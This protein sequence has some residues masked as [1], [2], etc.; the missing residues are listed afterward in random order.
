VTDPGR[1]DRPDL[2]ERH[3][4][5]RWTVE[6]WR[7]GA[8]ALHALDWPE[9]LRPTIWVLEVDRPALVLG[10][11]Q[12]PS[13]VDAAALARGGI[14]VASR[15]SGGGAVLLV[16]GDVVWIDVLIPASDPMWDPDVG[17]SFRWVGEAWAGALRDLGGRPLV[18]RGRLRRTERSDRVCFAGLGSGEVTLAGAKV[19]GL[20][21]RRT[22]RGARLST[23]AHL[24]WLVG[25]Y[26]ALS[27]VDPAALPPVA[28][29]DRPE[30]D[31]VAAVLAHVTAG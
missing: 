10:S 4:A 1:A 8:G 7:G 16:P 21:Q 11:T 25:P 18:H 6:R 29:I 26:G 14:E 22:R 24:R 13:A 20:S 28:T 23:A 27:G 31:V 9:P 17:R 12:H 2:L 30:A 5:G 3:R 15:R 19:V